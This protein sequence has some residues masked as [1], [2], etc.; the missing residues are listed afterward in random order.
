MINKTELLKLRDQAQQ[1]LFAV[2]EEKRQTELAAD[3]ARAAEHQLLGRLAL[4][5]EML[6]A[7][8]GTAE[9]PESVPAEEQGDQ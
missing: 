2:R 9:P 5:N 3:N 7:K 1:L 6:G 4:L 8:P